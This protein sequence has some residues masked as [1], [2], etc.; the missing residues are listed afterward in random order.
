MFS[1][2]FFE[3]FPEQL[4]YRNYQIILFTF[5]NQ[6]LAAREE[7]EHNNWEEGRLPN[8]RLQSNKYN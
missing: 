7:F 6:M 8:L 3:T 1:F 4:F 5:S 2:K